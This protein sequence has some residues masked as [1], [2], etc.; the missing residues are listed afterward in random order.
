MKLKKKVILISFVL[1]VLL[2]SVIVYATTSSAPTEKTKVVTSEMKNI[3][4]DILK[5]LNS[6]NSILSTNV[7][8]DD[9][10]EKDLYRVCTEKYMIDL[11]ASNNLVG[12]YCTNTSPV[13]TTTVATEEQARTM[14][15]NKYKELNLPSDYELS[16]LARFD[17]EIWQANFEKNYNGVYNKYES[18]KVFFIPENNEIVALTVFNEGHDDSPVSVSKE[19]AISSAAK[20]LGIDTSEIVSAS[21]SM[22]K[23]NNFYDKSNEDK[24]IHTSWVIQTSDNSIVYIDA[25]DNNVIGGDCV[26]E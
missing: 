11:D 24:S 14:I 25:S 10:R 21:L 22:E 8:Y 15:E 1:I 12:I 19:D 18:V 9:I 7:V 2:T 4:L 6:T 16:Y 5:T 23:A 26:N 20:N 13:S 3:S 17:D